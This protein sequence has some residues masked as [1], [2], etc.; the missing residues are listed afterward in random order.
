L[1]ENGSLA[2]L[3]KLSEQTMAAVLTTLAEFF[4]A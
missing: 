4:A 3:G 2:H 1:T